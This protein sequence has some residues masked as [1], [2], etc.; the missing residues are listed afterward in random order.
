MNKMDKI[1]KTL[2]EY[3]NSNSYP[4][5]EVE[6]IVISEDIWEELEF[7][8]ARNLELKVDRDGENF[9]RGILLEIDE[10]TPKGTVII[11]KK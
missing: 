10:L 8:F 1:D 2:W 9:Y 5:D 4:G 11:Y 6:K 3:Y 7:H